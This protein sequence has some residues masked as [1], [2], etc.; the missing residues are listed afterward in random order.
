[1]RFCEMIL[2]IMFLKTFMF[3]SYLLLWVLI[4]SAITFIAKWLKPFTTLIRTVVLENCQN[5]LYTDNR[6]EI[7]KEWF[8]KKIEIIIRNAPV[9]WF[10]FLLIEMLKTLDEE[11]DPHHGGFAVAAWNDD[12]VQTVGLHACNVK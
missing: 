10:I 6:C 5:C 4:V 9:L 11:I 1:M 7:D 8:K 12:D 2:K 3:S